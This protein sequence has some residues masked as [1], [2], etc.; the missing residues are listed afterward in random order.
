MKEVIEELREYKPTRSQFWKFNDVSY[1]KKKEEY[2]S[3][4][5]EFKEV[6]LLLEFKEVEVDKQCIQE[7]EV[8][9][10]FICFCLI[11]TIIFLPIVI[12]YYFA[13]FNAI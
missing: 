2:D 11:W 8:R 9:Q 4:L 12:F 13:D 3:L 7:L 5:L 6:A 1:E 10:K